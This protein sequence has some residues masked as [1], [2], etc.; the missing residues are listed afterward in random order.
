MKLNFSPHEL[1]AIQNRV[2]Q[3]NHSSNDKM[4]RVDY[5]MTELSLTRVQA[6]EVIEG[7]EK[8]IYSFHESYDAAVS[9]NDML[10]AIEG[11]IETMN[12][13]EKKAYLINV[14]ALIQLRDSDKCENDIDEYL[15]DFRSQ[16]SLESKTIQDIILEIQSAIKD[17]T[18][19]PGINEEVLDADLELIK[20]DENLSA[21]IKEYVDRE[22]YTKSYAAAI[23]VCMRK[24]EISIPDSLK[25]G[26]IIDPVA[27]GVSAAAGVEQA[28]ATSDYLFGKISKEVF[29]KTLR[30]I[31]AVA[32][33]CLIAY[34]A[35]VCLFG[36]TLLAFITID[37]GLSI[38]PLATMLAVLGSG[39]FIYEAFMALKNVA[40]ASWEW[41]KEKYQKFETILSS[42]LSCRNNTMSNNYESDS[43]NEEENKSGIAYA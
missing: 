25:D 30:I 14:L 3:I 8:G 31:S 5:M 28:K 35:Y 13:S 11:Y 40:E 37:L 27:V 21:K 34:A 19:I 32:F 22:S 41:S 15:K 24:G 39:F 20:K 4:S 18:Y 23:Y 43:I 42:K 17:T 12:E 38:G 26:D 36:V 9:S 33:W 1:K 7:L 6:E 10:A 16:K 2:E 29:L